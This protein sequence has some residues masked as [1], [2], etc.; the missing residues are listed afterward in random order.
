MFIDIPSHAF[1]LDPD[2][3]Y[4]SLVVKIEENQVPEDQCPTILANLE[5]RNHLLRIRVF[6]GSSLNMVFV[7]VLF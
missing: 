4:T 5:V 6:R 3:G 2:G 7:S 1:S